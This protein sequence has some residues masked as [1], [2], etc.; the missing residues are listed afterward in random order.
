MDWEELVGGIL[1]NDVLVFHNYQ[2]QKINNIETWTDAF[3][4]FIVI[5]W[6]VHNN[7]S[8]QEDQRGNQ[9]PYIEEEQTTQ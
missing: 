8:L 1:V 5:Y 7:I 4:Y 3:I 9:N 2:K 6:P